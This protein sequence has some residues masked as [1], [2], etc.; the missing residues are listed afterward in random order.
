MESAL[1]LHL[2]LPRE[3]DVH[4]EGPTTMLIAGNGD[5]F[6]VLNRLAQVAVA[7]PKGGYALLTDAA[8]GMPPRPHAD[9]SVGALVT[10]HKT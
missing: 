2:A 4:L 8:R 1:A 9:L 6:W 7:T 5:L 3:P 10:L